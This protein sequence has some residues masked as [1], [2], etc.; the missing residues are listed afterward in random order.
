[1]SSEPPDEASPRSWEDASS[2]GALANLADADTEL[3]DANL[4]ANTAGTLLAA[5]PPGAS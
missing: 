1:M 3:D 2:D 5:S 4:S